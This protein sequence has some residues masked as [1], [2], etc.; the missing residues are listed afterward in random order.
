VRVIV[1]GN[2]K[3][4]ILL[5]TKEFSAV[6]IETD[7]GKPTVIYKN[8]AGGKSWVRLTKGEDSEFDEVAR[9]LK[10]V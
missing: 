8:I 9:Q 6:L 5:D 7:D 10:L 4:P 3:K 1:A 2:I